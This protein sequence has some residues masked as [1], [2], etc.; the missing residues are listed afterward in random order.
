MS[1]DPYMTE[2]MVV[3][4]Y[5]SEFGDAGGILNIVEEFNEVGESCGF[6]VALFLHASG[7]LSST[8][9]VHTI[10]REKLGKVADALNNYLAKT[11][12]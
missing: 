6:R 11:R 2:K 12:E 4:E 1:K 5:L 7:N 10:R 9:I 8:T 3:N